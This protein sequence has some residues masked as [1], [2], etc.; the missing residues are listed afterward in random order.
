MA[1]KLDAI[2]LKILKALMADGRLTNVALAAR[3]GLS[4]PPCLRRTRALEAAGIISGYH[5]E[6]DTTALGF[7]VTAFVT[8]ALHNQAEPDLR[9]FEELVLAWPEVR[10][11]Y[12]MSG[13]TDYHLKCLTR[14][15]TTFQQFLTGTVSSA[16]NV[17]SVKAQVAM[18]RA[19]FKPGVPL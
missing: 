2:D 8:V 6:A 11:A 10:E 5:A 17:A 3:V 12:M 19:K 4:G 18:R 1:Y 15:L 13:E 7:T 9:A 14:D 16:A